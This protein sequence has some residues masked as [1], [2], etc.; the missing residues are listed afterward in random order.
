M[1]RMIAVDDGGHDGQPDGDGAD[2]DGARAGAQQ[3][4]AT[5]L[6]AV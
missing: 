6:L 1:C 2:A 4:R 3:S 5:Q